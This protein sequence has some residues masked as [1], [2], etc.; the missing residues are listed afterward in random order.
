MFW[1]GRCTHCSIWCGALRDCPG[2]TEL[3]AGD[4]VTTGTWT[5]TWPVEPGQQWSAQFDSPLSTLEATFD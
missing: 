4:V 1:T 2:A 5:D 3:R